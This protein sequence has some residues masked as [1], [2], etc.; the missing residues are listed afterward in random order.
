MRVR[1]R[2]SLTD[3]LMND[4]EYDALHLV[5]HDENNYCP[6]LVSNLMLACLAYASHVFMRNI[7]ISC[8]QPVIIVMDM[9]ILPAHNRGTQGHG[10]PKHVRMR[11]LTSAPEHKSI[12]ILHTMIPT[13]GSCSKSGSAASSLRTKK[14]YRCFGGRS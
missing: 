10:S 6:L 9:P 5:R 2:K 3:V 11:H 4:D 8:S 14:G 12:T 1:R 7:C 13:S